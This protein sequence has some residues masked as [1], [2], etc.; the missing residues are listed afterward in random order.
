MKKQISY[1]KAIEEIEDIINY[2]SGDSVD[3][4]KLTDNVKRATELIKT[5]KERL[6]EVDQEVNK[7]MT[8]NEE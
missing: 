7:I 3:V 4:D 8:S 5:C 2:I 6:L 1:S